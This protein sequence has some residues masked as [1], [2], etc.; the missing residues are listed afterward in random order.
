MN[1]RSLLARVILIL[2]ALLLLGC[3]ATE[4]QTQPPEF[5]DV[6]LIEVW[7]RGGIHYEVYCTLPTSTTGIEYH[8]IIETSEKLEA[9]QVITL[10]VY[11][12]TQKQSHTFIYEPSNF[13]R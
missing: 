8:I 9:G 13:D 1:A 10:P 3:K 6:K 4:P 7:P 2:G 11:Q 5:I 12:M